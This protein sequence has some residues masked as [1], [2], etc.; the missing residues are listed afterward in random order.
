MS[1]EPFSTQF[2]VWWVLSAAL[3]A[4]ALVFGG[5]FLG[6]NWSSDDEDKE[7]APKPVETTAKA[8]S[9]ESSGA[10]GVPAEDQDYPTE[11]PETQWEMYENVLSMPTSSA[12]GPTKKDGPF[13]HCFAHSPKGALFA[14]FALSQAFT[15]GEVYEAAVDTPGA[16]EIFDENATNQKSDPPAVEI[17]GFQI[18]SYS[19]TAATVVLLVTVNGQQASTPIQLVWDNT[20]D[21]WRWDAENTTQPELVE[22]DDGFT[23]WS[24]RHG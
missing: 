6:V 11:A 2:N 7:A 14:S 13:W 3:I 10:C 23:K 17:A 21:D 20:A 16:K 4:A 15:T 8:D 5:I 22:N 9:G 24:P 18:E 12:Y 19:E 1:K